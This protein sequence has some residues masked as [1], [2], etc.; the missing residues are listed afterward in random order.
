MGVCV[1]WR[2]VACAAVVAVT[3]SAAASAQSEGSGT[4]WLPVESPM[5]AVHAK[6]GAWTLMS[7]E[8]LFLQAIHE[9][10][11]RGADQAGSINWV[12][13]MAERDVRGGHLALRGMVSL[14]PWTIRGCGYPDLLASGEICHGSDIHD[15]QHPHDLPMEIA[16]SY[17]APL[18]RSLRWQVYGGPAGEP[19][20]GPVAFAHRPS[21]MPN[22]LAPIAHHWLDST[23]LSFGVVTGAIYGSRWKAE[24]SSFNGR[25][26]DEQR[27]D[28]DFGAMDSVSGRVSFAVT[29]ALVVQFSGG[30]LVQ[31]AASLAG[32]SRID[33]QRM[34]SSA[35]YHRLRGGNLWASTVA[36]G[37]NIQ[38]GMAT[39]AWLSETSLT[40]HDRHT[41]YGRVEIVGKTPDELS[42]ADTAPVLTVSKVEA[43]FTEYLGA[44][45][46]LRP[47]IG[48]E[49][50]S[51]RVPASIAA[52]YGGRTNPGA[53]VYLTLRPRAMQTAAGVAMV[54]VQTALDPARLSCAA[55]FD[56]A[57]A[58][59]TTYQ[60]KMYYFCSPADRD[61]F[62]KDPAMSLSMRP[63][64]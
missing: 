4:S 62:V 17:D 61:A 38:G 56:P 44:L 1:R 59:M 47:G 22:P 50:F 16:V 54:M 45:H 52:S 55:G 26:P 5:Y 41:I 9:G 37:R 25:E 28:F 7:H 58:A 60:G 29:P 36:W 10:G 30:H 64:N 34:T 21:A 13:E 14:E 27:T 46:G 49:V 20:L 35:T 33:V 39:D 6:A 8:N 11:R 53:A 24:I 15:R 40:L 31:A 32:G 18:A 42:V 43:G 63:P 3:W 23:H 12:M 57:R 48:I 51:S 19:A 2:R